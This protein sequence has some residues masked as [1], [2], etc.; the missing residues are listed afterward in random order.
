MRTDV[1]INGGSG[2]FTFYMRTKRAQRWVNAHVQLAS[3]QGD[4]L[5]FVCD[6]TRMAQDIARA[7]Q[8][9]GLRVV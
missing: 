4:G 1:E 2:F 8:S 6:D 3:W 7:M 9:E 5:Q